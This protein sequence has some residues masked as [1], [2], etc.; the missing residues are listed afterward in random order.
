MM[1]PDYDLFMA[2][3]A[4]GSLSA[5]GRELNASPAMMSKRLSRLE[6]RLGVR[7][8]NRS[9]R[10]LSLTSQGERL[11]TDLGAIRAELEQAEARVRG[12]LGRPAGPLRMSAPTSFG[13]MHLA[14]FIARFLDE[15]PRV[16]L[17]LDLSDDF[18]DLMGAPYDLAIRITSNLPKSLA[19]HRLA[20]SERILCAAPGYI[21]RHGC[22]QTIAELRLHRLLAAAGQLPWRLEGPAGAVVVH[23][24]SQ[25]PTNSSELVREL[26]ISG[27]GIALR[28]LWDI[29]GELQRGQLVRVLPQFGGLQDS[30]IYAVHL[31]SPLPNPALAAMVSFL[32]RLYAPTAPWESKAKG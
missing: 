8:L 9:T 28:S 6:G 31:P 21:R 16:N 13:R 26:A 27:A 5:A 32:A 12:E 24:V 2:I 23:G 1:D 29:H 7:L 30:A 15:H 3:V 14:P 4:A 17:T 25:V 11:H 22:P 19:A 18:L 10:R 20:A